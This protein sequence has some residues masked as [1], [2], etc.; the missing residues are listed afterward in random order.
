M[1]V[2]VGI[3]LALALVLGLSVACSSKEPVEIVIDEYYPS[4]R[5]LPPEPVYSR[6]AWSNLPEPVPSAYS[7][8]SPYL[9][10]VM[11]FDLPRSNLEEALEALSQTIG[12][13]L[14]YPKKLRRKPVSLQVEGT[15]D[16][17]AREIARQTNLDVHL[18]HGARRVEVSQ[19]R[20]PVQ[21]RLPAKAH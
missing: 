1:K 6:L 17:V 2:E 7:K 16:E 13:E 3:K 20:S 4:T 10:P 8:K 12:Y 14:S 5:Q 19:K 9:R 21:P 15:V 11:A 18:N